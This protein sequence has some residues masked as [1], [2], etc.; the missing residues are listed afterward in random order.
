MAAI[1]TPLLSS[2]WCSVLNFD[3]S[4]FQFPISLRGPSLSR[5][6]VR[7]DIFNTMHVGPSLTKRDASNSNCTWSSLTLRKQG[8]VWLGTRQ[9][10]KGDILEKTKR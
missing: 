1:L 9:K 8:C 3:P 7:R 5:K 4:N 10:K 2:L 6:I